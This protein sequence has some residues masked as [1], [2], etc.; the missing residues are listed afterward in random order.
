MV[1]LSCRK[2]CV[3]Y[4][5]IGLWGWPKMAKLFRPAS[6]PFVVYQVSH[7]F[8]H[9][10]P[11]NTEPLSTWVFWTNASEVRWINGYTTWVLLQEFLHPHWG[12]L[13][14]SKTVQILTYKHILG[15]AGLCLYDF[16]YLPTYMCCIYRSFYKSSSLKTQS[17]QSGKAIY[18]AT[19][20]KL[21]SC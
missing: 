1:S 14:H 3:F 7:K 2:A 6:L 17:Q 19:S 13:D 4:I 21:H 5:C 20:D 16:S 10:N 8:Y 18:Q 9:Q 15:M 11:V 12:E